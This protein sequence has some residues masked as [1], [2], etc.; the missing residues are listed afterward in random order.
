MRQIVWLLLLIVPLLFSCN[1]DKKK[2]EQQPIIP[3]EKFIRLLTDIHKTDGYFSSIKQNLI[4]DTTL[5][6]KNFF[7]EVFHKYGVTN[8]DFQATILYYCYRMDEFEIIYE[9]VV[10]NLNQENDSLQMITGKKKMPEN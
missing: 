4:N 7:G 9:Q 10:Q 3:K 5:N 8:K 1:S 2:E 6:P